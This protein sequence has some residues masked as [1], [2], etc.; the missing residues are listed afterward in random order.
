MHFK[1]VICKDYVC[2]N[3]TRPW[4][5]LDPRHVEL[6]KENRLVRDMFILP[7][8]MGWK[9]ESNHMDITGEYNARLGAGPDANEMTAYPS[10][11][12]AKEAWG[13]DNSLKV[14]CDS[15][16]DALPTYNTVIFVAHQFYYNQGTKDYTSVITEKTAWGSQIY[17]GCG[18]VRRGVEML[19]KP[20]EY[21]N[22]RTI[23]LVASG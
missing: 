16:S 7:V 20:V 1:N 3:G 21:D 4:D 9:T 15:D 17:P 19:F 13:L 22:T 11:F 18:K 5:P 12:I 2:G 6:Y 10:A 23:M 14:G 8:P